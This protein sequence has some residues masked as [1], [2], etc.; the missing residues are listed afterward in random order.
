MAAR[1]TVSR[2]DT[3][4]VPAA[5]VALHLADADRRLGALAAIVTVNSVDEAELAWIARWLSEAVH[6]TRILSAGVDGAAAAIV[7]TD[8]RNAVQRIAALV[9]EARVHIPEHG[10]LGDPADR[11]LD[12]QR[13]DLAQGVKLVIAAEAAADGHDDI[14]T[15]TAR[16]AAAIEDLIG[17]DRDDKPTPEVGAAA[18]LSACQAL[19]THALPIVMRS[20]RSG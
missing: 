4:T 10:H 12:P 19:S 9:I 20:R 6:A 16:L 2:M 17:A 13:D 11:S 1:R 8:L 7:A 3:T 5:S 14:L 15:D 18:V